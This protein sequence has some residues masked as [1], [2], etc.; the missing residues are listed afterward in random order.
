[1]AVKK[2]ITKSLTKYAKRRMMGRFSRRTMTAAQKRAL[3]KA[4]KASALARSKGASRRAAKKVAR[5]S[6]EQSALKSVKKMGLKQTGTSLDYYGK[7]LAKNAF[8]SKAVQK[9]TYRTR[10]NASRAAYNNLSRSKK[11]A[12]AAKAYQPM[13]QSLWRREYQY[14]TYGENVVRN[15]TRDLKVSGASTAAIAGTYGSYKLAKGLARNYGNISFNGF[16]NNRRRSA[17]RKP[18]V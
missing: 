6:I 1:M 17:R 7:R 14:L 12:M 10:L 13:T 15:F 3:A 2:A 11:I 4:V 18:N 16:R 5:R 8:K 9:A